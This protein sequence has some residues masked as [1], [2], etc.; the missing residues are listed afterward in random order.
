MVLSTVQELLPKYD[1]VR[2]CSTGGA[3][4]NHF[5]K[6]F[7][8][9]MLLKF[10][11]F[12]AFYIRTYS[13][14]FAQS[15]FIKEIKYDLVEFLNHLQIL[16]LKGKGTPEINQSVELLSEGLKKLPETKKKDNMKLNTSWKIFSWCI[17]SGAL[18]TIISFI[19]EYA[20]LIL[21][22]GVMVITLLIPLVIDRL[23]KYLT[24]KHWYHIS[25]KNQ[26]IGKLKKQLL[27]ELIQID[28]S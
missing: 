8:L 3:F 11:P 15:R 16:Q 19:F 23:L 9:T 22:V 6:I 25:Q 21:L 28:K 27:D 18:I 10:K 12:E 2:S 13:F 7:H 24:E 5:M 17:P 20:P 14:P 4:D 1:K 26:G